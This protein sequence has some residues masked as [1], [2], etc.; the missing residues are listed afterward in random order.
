MKRLICILCLVVCFNTQA[1]TLESKDK[2]AILNLIEDQRQAW[3][4][5]DIDTFM[6]SY[7]KSDSL[8]FYG[9]NGVTNGWK[10]TLARYKKSYPTKAHMGHLNFK[11]NAVTKIDDGAYYVMGEYHLTRDIGNANGIFMII[12]KKIEGEWKI[13]ADTSC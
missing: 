2:T 7:W 3:N 11:I 6:S 8:K 4:N 5:N 9:S 12:L 1:Q 10:N 13:I